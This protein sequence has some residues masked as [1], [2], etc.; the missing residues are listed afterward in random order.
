MSWNGIVQS[1]LRTTE[2]PETSQFSV[3]TEICRLIQ[4]LAL[5]HSILCSH[6]GSFRPSV[7]AT[8][9]FLR[10]LWTLAPKGF[11]A[12]HLQCQG[13]FSCCGFWSELQTAFGSAS[14]CFRSIEDVTCL[15]STN[16]H[17]QKLRYQIYG[18][19]KHNTK[20]Y[21]VLKTCG[22]IR[23]VMNESNKSILHSVLY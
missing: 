13:G 5:W 9:C 1:A 7:N 12:V 11:A 22:D 19:Q 4:S 3:L 17:I 16:K 23:F 21:Q 14:C 6:T 8:E 15:S 18:T 20:R 2:L 10:R